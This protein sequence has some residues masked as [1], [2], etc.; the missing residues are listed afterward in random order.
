MVTYLGSLVQL[1]CEEGGTLLTNITG[2]C[3]ECS[4]CI[5]HTGFATAQGCVCFWVYTAR[6]PGYSARAVSKAGPAFHTLPRSK[7]LRF[8][9]TPQ[10]HRLSCVCVLC[11][12]QVQTAQSTRC[13]GEHTLPGGPCILITSPVL[14]AQFPGCA[15][16]VSG[17]PCVSSRELIS[18]CDPFGRC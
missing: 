10:G 14:V 1:C 6:A 2:V 4:Q 18:G 17:V 9:G 5:D 13:F 7:W 11:H 12:T 16:T 3:G 8:P 15:T